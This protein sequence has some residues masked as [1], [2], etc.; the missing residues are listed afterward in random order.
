MSH[1]SRTQA[2]LHTDRFAMHSQLWILDAHLQI[3]VQIC[4]A[5]RSGFLFFSFFSPNVLGVIELTTRWRLFEKSLLIF[6]GNC[7]TPE[8]KHIL[9][10]LNVLSTSDQQLSL[11]RNQLLLV[12]LKNQTFLIS[13]VH[14]GPTF[15]LN[16]AGGTLRSD[17]KEDLQGD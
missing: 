2:D 15:P 7:D 11:V 8:N 13:L 1:I 9:R 4:Q 5:M 16:H 12:L 17:P 3:Y 6:S 14:L 10:H